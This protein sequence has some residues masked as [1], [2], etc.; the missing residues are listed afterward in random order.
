MQTIIIG[1][2]GHGKVVLDILRSARK[3]KYEPVGWLDANA[4]L[5]GTDISGLPVLGGINLLAKLRQQKIKH[6][7]VAIGDNRVRLGY[8]R[9][10]KEA[11]L[12]LINAIH[13]AATVSKSAHL[14]KNLVI[15]A[16]AVIAAEARISDSVIINTSAV[17][18][19]ECEVGD[20]AHICP[21]VALGGRVRVGT[22]AFIGIGSKVLPCLTIG[23]SAIV[24]AGAVVIA[25]VPSESTVVGV[26]AKILNR[27]E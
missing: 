9:S 16:N 25:D 13:P 6:A 11:G 10:V 4:S 27:K 1:A 2:G 12:E 19:H 3:P 24:G 7:I 15:A 17:V 14:G 21:T 18:D 22:C 8:A 20:A 23:D 26:P 5:H